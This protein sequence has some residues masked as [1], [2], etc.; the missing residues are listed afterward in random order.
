MM[1]DAGIPKCVLC[2]RYLYVSNGRLCPF[3]QLW[4]TVAYGA[5]THDEQALLFGADAVESANVLTWRQHG[6]RS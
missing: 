4:E 3:H 5:R 6:T 2:D 1:S